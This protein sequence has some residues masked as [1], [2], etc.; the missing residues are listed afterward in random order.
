[1]AKRPGGPRV[2]PSLALLARPPGSCGTGALAHIDMKERHRI[3]VEGIVQGVG[4]RPFVYGLATKNGLTGFVRNDTTGVIIEVEGE[5]LALEAFL[6]V[7][8]EEPPPLASIERSATMHRLSL[9]PS[10]E[11]QSPA[12]SMCLG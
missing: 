2:A 5:P 1:M 10:I 7:L 4:F 12:H 3:F 6:R 9:T 8:R 11:V